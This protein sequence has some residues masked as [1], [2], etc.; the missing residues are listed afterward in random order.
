MVLRY[1]LAS[2]LAFLTIAGYS[3]TYDWGF[4]LDGVGVGF[5]PVFGS[6]ISVAS[7]DQGN[8]YLSGSYNGIYDFDPSQ[9]SVTSIS[10]GQSDFYVAKYDSIGHLLWVRFFGDTGNDI[11]YCLELDQDGQ[12][13]ISGKFNGAIDFD[14]GPGAQIIQS[15]PNQNICIKT[16][17]RRSF[18]MG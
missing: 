7:D 9:N 3:Q 10:F 2:V 15:G 16:K 5:S 11:V 12:P 17:C 14:P 13:I 1:L 4:G 18:S 8:V 6:D